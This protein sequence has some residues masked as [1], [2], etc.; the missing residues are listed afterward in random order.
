MEI[1]QVDET[2]IIKFGK[3]WLV[4]WTGNKPE[5]L[6][7]FY[8]EDAFYLDPAKPKGLK[9]REE[10][11]QY[12][13]KLLAANPNW[14]WEAVEV[15]PTKK[16]FTAKWKA[17]IPVGTKVIIEYGMDIVEVE[18]GKIKRNEVYFN[19]SN[20]FSALKNE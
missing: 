11:F 5:K 9:G 16:G 10:I 20:L 13:K 7:E 4:A 3:P 18:N 19:T 15:F 1:K 2:E 12:F 17:T 8:S 14:I 6:I